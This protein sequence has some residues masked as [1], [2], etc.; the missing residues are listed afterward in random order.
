MSHVEG[1]GA[2][3][4]ELPLPPQVPQAPQ[5]PDL[6]DLPELSAAA[7]L[8]VEGARAGRVHDI[9]LHDA[10]G[11]FAAISVALGRLGGRIILVPAAALDSEHPDAEGRV[12]LRIPARALR[13]GLEAPATLHAEPDLLVRAGRALGLEESAP[14]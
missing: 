3:E 6:P 2:G 9:Y 12:H 5:V 11:E 8:D 14:A 7:V 13:E 10:S 1:A 4:Q